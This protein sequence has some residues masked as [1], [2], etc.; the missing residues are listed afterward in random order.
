MS[1]RR[2]GILSQLVPP[3]THWTEEKVPDQRGK[4]VII[5]GGN[6]GIGKQT[7]RVRISFPSVFDML[8]ADLQ[9]F[10]RCCY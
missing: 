9:S 1:V 3:R 8:P 4:T 2:I 10:L 5:T 6:I 7:A